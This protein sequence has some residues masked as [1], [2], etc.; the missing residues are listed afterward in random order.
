MQTGTVLSK[1]EGVFLHFLDPGGERSKKKGEAGCIFSN[2]I[3]KLGAQGDRMNGSLS[4][5]AA[6]EKWKRP[7]SNWFIKNPTGE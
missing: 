4:H 2:N 7:S 5:G 3:R 1:W 6:W